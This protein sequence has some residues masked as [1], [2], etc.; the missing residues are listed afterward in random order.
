MI[1]FLQD[2]CNQI[3]RY[4]IKVKV[5]KSVNRLYVNKVKSHKQRV[6]GHEF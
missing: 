2:N 5:N 3:A 6:L 1:Y 4:L